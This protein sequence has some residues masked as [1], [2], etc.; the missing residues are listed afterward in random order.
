MDNPQ[1]TFVDKIFYDFIKGYKFLLASIFMGVF[2]GFI[3]GFLLL[4]PIYKSEVITMLNDQSNQ[5]VSFGN[6]NIIQSLVGIGGGSQV[7][8]EFA[9]IQY[10]VNSYEFI[11][12]FLEIKEIKDIY[13]S[14]IKNMSPYGLERFFRGKVDLLQDKKS[15]LIFISVKDHNPSNAKIFAENLIA[16]INK[17]YVAIEGTSADL[18]IQY[19]NEEL[20][21]PQSIYLRSNLTAMLERALQL[22]MQSAIEKD[23]KLKII[24]PPDSIKPKFAPRR[25]IILALSFLLS[26]IFFIS[27]FLAMNLHK[28]FKNWVFGKAFFRKLLGY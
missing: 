8:N 19:I 26:I 28:P 3:Y 24:D 17:F 22:K 15:Q 7:S 6:Q 4:K 9:E 5:Q 20:S 10:T 23:Y 21:Q 13:H 11:K 18:R 12:D 27:F 14:K 16:F 25:S 1:H 2:I